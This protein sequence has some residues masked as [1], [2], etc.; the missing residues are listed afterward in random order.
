MKRI[1]WI[2]C[3]ALTL[4]ACGEKNNPDPKPEDSLSVS[5]TSLSF[6]E[7]DSSTK[8]VAVTA[9]GSWTAS[10]SA[11]WMHVTPTSGSGNASLSVT[12]DAN[13]ADGAR[14]ATINL[15]CGSKSASV[16]VTQAGAGK[17]AIV[18]PAP[19]AFDGNKRASTTYQLLVYSFADSDG[20][21]V[22]DFK[23]IQNKLDYLDGL[24]V[25]ALWLS[26]SHPTH[27]YH[28]YDVDDY[29]TVNPL[30]GTE[31]D[32]KNLIDAA[33]GRGIKIYMD[34]VLNLAAAI[35]GSRA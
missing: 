15:A 31:A 26:P 7:E 34:F 33:H 30:F 13:T 21:G 17:V 12:V 5:P 24:G 6:T 20:D 11:A 35:P 2:L 16:S 9:S 23:G 22:G 8:L 10:A 27:S 18:P 29:M 28:G 1:L 4:A 32:F 25:T 14:T 19:A 3:A